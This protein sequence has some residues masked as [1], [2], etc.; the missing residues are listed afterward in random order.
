VSLVTSGAWGLLWYREW[1]GLAALAWCAAAAVTM[2]SVILL[3]F[4]KGGA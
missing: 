3:G 4:E 2:A 1:S